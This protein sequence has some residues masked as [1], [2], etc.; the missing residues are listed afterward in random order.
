MD[1]NSPT[2]PNPDNNKSFPNSCFFCCFSLS[3]IFKL[4]ISFKLEFI[5]AV[6]ASLDTSEYLL[7][8]CLNLF[9]ISI[10]NFRKIIK[11]L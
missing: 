5:P 1:I 2:S 10:S 6:L 3:D 7:A 4:S 9:H 8:I 11:I